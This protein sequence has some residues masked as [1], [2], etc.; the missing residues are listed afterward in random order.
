[1]TS[2]VLPYTV[3]LINSLVD[4]LMWIQNLKLEFTVLLPSI[5]VTFFNRTVRFQLD[6]WNHCCLSAMLLLFLCHVT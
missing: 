1:M 4:I 5:R 6:A 3:G 2:F